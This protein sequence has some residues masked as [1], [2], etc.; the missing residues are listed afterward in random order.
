MNQVLS[1]FAAQSV[2]IH[3]ELQNH[4]DILSMHSKVIVD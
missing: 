2:T 4:H 1:S 3:G